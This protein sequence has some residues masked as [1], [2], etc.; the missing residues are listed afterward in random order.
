MLLKKC[1]RDEKLLTKKIN[2][3]P[4]NDMEEKIIKPHFHQFKTARLKF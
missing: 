3:H 4:E 2:N 1:P